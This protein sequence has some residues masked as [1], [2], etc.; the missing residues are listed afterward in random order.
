[1][2][3]AL[4]LGL[5]L[6]SVTAC[7]STNSSLDIVGGQLVRG[8]DPIATHTIALVETEGEFDEYCTAVL[9]APNAA[10]TAAH[11][12]LEPKK[13]PMLFFGSQIP[14]SRQKA[15]KRFVELN[16][17][18][19]HPDFTQKKLNAFDEKIRDLKSADK[20]P[21]PREPLDDLAI[22]FFKD[23]QMEAYSPVA[24]AK[25]LPQEEKTVA[26]GFGCLS[27]ACDKL[28][29]RLRKV[30]LSLDR[31]LGDSHLLV[32]TAGRDRGTCTGD[33]GGPDFLMGGPRLELLSI[34]STGPISCEAGLSIETWVAPYL[35]WIDSIIKPNSP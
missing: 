9:I 21:V 26:A 20:I 12:F 16:E 31:K 28:S 33:S 19:I 35:E 22:V 30:E 27:T 11:C 7:R 3:K 18:I 6:L 8:S 15:D 4:G 25:D 17:I 10:L 29:N 1:M 14:K 24:L 34:V 5:A 13:H 32:M 23:P 2:I